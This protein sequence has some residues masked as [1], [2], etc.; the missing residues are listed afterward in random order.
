MLHPDFTVFPEIKTERLVLRK[1]AITD[2]PAVLQLRADENVMRYI[3]RER[4]ATIA[5]AE[6]YISKIIQ[7]LSNNEGI[8]WAIALKEEP[9][10]L[11]G[12]IGYWRLIKEHFR[13]EIGYMLSPVHWNK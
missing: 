5:D 4:A 2:A 11:I 6:V 8:T 3:D 9:A 10:K 1:L 13:A 7:S 12:T